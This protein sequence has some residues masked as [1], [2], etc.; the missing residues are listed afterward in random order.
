M[1][2]DTEIAVVGAGL[3]GLALASALRT[4]GR[5]VTVLEARD[6]P[7]GRVLSEDGYD[8]GPAWI[9]PHNTRMRALAKALGLTTFPQ[10][11]AGRLVF[12]PP[13]GGIRR[14]LELAT[15]GDALRIDGGLA[16]MTSALGERL[17]DSLHLNR[18]VR[19]IEEDADGV[20]LTGEGYSIRAERVVL[21]L[22]PRLA[23]PLGV[24]ARD[25]PTWMAGHAK[26]VA[27]YS[28]PFWRQAGLNG[29]GISHRGPLAEIHDA[30]P[31]DAAEGALFGFAVPG[32][33]RHPEFPS[34]AIEQLTRLF[35]PE[36]AN[37]T[38]VFVKDWSTDPETATERDRM[39]P[40]AHPSYR[41]QPTTPR[42]IFSGSETAS[43][44][45]GFLEGALEAA[46][47]AQAILRRVA[48]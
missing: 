12:E 24:E 7:G 15:M 21:A 30:S 46:E 6:R 13:S 3:S 34:A 28:E 39:P 45:G 18:A 4:E 26:F 42:L 33:A 5:D 37:P 11:S 8:L 23:A 36:A 43:L 9:W 44:H 19:Q 41:A 14:D 38:G 1:T 29:D 35:G 40:A 22:P 31:M 10:H 25:V 2:S 20:S 17:G 27:R 48:A 47:A 16:Q 32:A